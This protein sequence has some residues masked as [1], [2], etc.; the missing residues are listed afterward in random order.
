MLLKAILRHR[1]H[2]DHLHDRSWIALAELN[3]SG[4]KIAQV[5]RT[6]FTI[7][8]GQ[9]RELLIQAICWFP[10]PKLA[11]ASE[12]FRV[13]NSMALPSLSRV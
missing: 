7:F 5:F 12:Y 2:V 3:Q 10:E 9:L 1:C 6:E 8:R 4:K 13:Y 11:A